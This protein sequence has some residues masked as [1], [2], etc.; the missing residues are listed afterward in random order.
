[1]PPDGLCGKI[2]QRLTGKITGLRVAHPFQPQFTQWMRIRDE[3]FQRAGTVQEVLGDVGLAHDGG[4]KV[5][6][7]E[8]RLQARAGWTGTE[9]NS[10][11]C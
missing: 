7:I 2:E 8:Q 9:I 3:F 5:E 11:P 4:G 1:M 6:L 10:T